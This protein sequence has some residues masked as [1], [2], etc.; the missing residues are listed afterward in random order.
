MKKKTNPWAWVPTLYIGEGLPNVVVTVVAATMFMQLGMV[1]TEITF[2]VGWL[3]LPWIIKPLWSPFVDLYNTKRWWV[4]AMQALLSSA[5][6]GVAFMLNTSIWFQGVLAFLF[7]MA[8]S[9][10]THDIAADGY[11][12]LELDEHQQAWFVGIRNTFYRLAVIFG[13][14]VFIPLAGVFAV[15]F[16]GQKAFAWSLVFY[17]VAGLFLALWLYHVYIMPKPKGDQPHETTARDVICGIKQTFITYCRKMPLRETMFAIIFILFYRFPESLLN[18]VS[19]TFLQRKVSEGGLGLTPFEFGLANGT[20]GTV[21]LLLGGILGGWLASRD[22]LKKWLWTMVCALTL[23]DIIYVYLSMAMPN[24]LVIV[25]TCLFVEQFGYGLGFTALTLYMLYYSQGAFK[26]SHYAICTGISYL[27]LTI[28]GM[29]S[30][31]VKDSVGYPTFFLIVMFS[32][33]ITFLV[34]AFL[35]IDPAFGKKQSP[36]D[37]Q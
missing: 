26:T 22:G 2:Y 25:S 14:G 10:A 27:G 11:Y 20:V 37:N 23:P 7:L 15:W 12:M 9:S 28:P 32:C 5:Y 21:G 19:I 34:T 35:K 4:L 16:R 33:I 30:G 1:D 24:S 8:F 17:A 29:L 3:G 6:A 18:T 31:Y 36:D 13:K